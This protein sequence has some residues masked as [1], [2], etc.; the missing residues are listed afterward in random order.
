[1]WGMG[2]GLDGQL[3]LSKKMDVTLPPRTIEA[4]SNIR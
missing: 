3:G 1:M 2:W 4:L